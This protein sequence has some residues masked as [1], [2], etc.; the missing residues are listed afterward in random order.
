MRV[1]SMLNKL[2]AVCILLTLP[3]GV[4]AQHQPAATRSAPSPSDEW[5]P[6]LDERVVV[7][8]IEE[9]SSGKVNLAAMN[10]RGIIVGTIE[11]E[12]GRAVFRWSRRHGMELL[13]GFPDGARILDI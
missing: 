4:A 9:L 3:G 12:D 11:T 2:L 8:V 5:P 6:P 1:A 13:D 7:T 10:D